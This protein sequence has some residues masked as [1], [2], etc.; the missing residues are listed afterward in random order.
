M[1]LLLFDLPPTRRPVPLPILAAGRLP[2]DVSRRRRVTATD[3]FVKRSSSAGL[4]D[5]NCRFVVPAAP[6]CHQQH[7]FPP[8]ARRPEGRERSATTSS[9]TTVAMATRAPFHFRW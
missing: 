5:V 7:V 2:N 3:W 4:T 8:G 9:T 1:S 6:C